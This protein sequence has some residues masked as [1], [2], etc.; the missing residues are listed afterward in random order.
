MARLNR[1]PEEPH[2]E[3]KIASAGPAVNLAAVLGLLPLGLA[4][5]DLSAARLLDPM[6]LFSME[7][8]TAPSLIR[9]ALGVN[10][11]MGVFN[12]VPAFPLDGGRILRAILGFRLGFA[13]ATFVAVQVSR[14]LSVTLLVAALAGLLGDAVSLLGLSVI[15]LFVFMA[16]AQEQ[17]A[18]LVRTALG[19]AREPAVQPRPVESSLRMNREEYQRFLEEHRDRGKTGEL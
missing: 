7:G 18:V 17:R 13:K 4:F 14:W 19:A 5:G 16:G 9:F 10:L 11:M 6:F 1:M 3:L 12:L 2:I 15:V 8:L